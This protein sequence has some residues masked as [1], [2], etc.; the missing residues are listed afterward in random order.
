VKLKLEPFESLWRC[1]VCGME[2]ITP[3]NDP[4]DK[5]PRCPIHTSMSW[6]D[7]GEEYPGENDPPSI[8]G[9]GL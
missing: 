6:V 8:L 7:S 4:P 5:C 3:H 9:S 2:Q 1:D